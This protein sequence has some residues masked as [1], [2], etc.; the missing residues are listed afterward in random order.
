MMP[1]ENLMQ[2][3]SLLPPLCCFA[4]RV[5]WKLPH[6]AARHCAEVQGRNM[7][8][9]GGSF[10]V[11]GSPALLALAIRLEAIGIKMI[12]LAGI[13]LAVPHPDTGIGSLEGRL[14]CK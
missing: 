1:A 3:S 12:V 7:R 14:F 4:T 9:C 13:F 2:L 6:D 11:K 10:M 5:R 8:V